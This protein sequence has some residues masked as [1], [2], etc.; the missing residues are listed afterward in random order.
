M[1]KSRGALVAAMALLLVIGGVSVAGALPPTPSSK[2]TPSQGCTC[3]TALLEQW[4]VSMHAQAL[5][6]PL[7]RFKLDQAKK[8]GGEQLG[9][10]CEN[11]HA[12]VAVMSGEI[13]DLSKAT[14]QSLQGVFCDFCHQ[15]T[16]TAGQI[17]NV[18]QT[19]MPD[20]TK[21]AQFDDA[22]SPVHT[23]AYSAFH[24]TAEFCGS[25]HNVDHPSDRTMHLET[26]Y[27][28]W[29]DSPYAADGIVCQDCH[30]TPGPGVTKPNPGTAAGAGPQ[31]DHIYTMT[32]AGGN[33]ALGDAKRAEER[34]KA[35][36]EVTLDAPE[37]VAAGGEAV[38]T[39]T[40]AN[41]G[42]G[43][44]IPTGLTTLREM[45][46][47]LSA[48][49]AAGEAVLVGEHRFGTV[50][51]D[52]KGVAPAEV[53]NAVAVESDDRIR[54]GES[55]T[56]TFTLE[57]PSRATTLTATLYY[58]SCPEAYAKA[59]GVEVPTTTMASAT[60]VVYTSAAERTAAREDP[61]A[62]RNRS[63]AV[64]VAAGGVVLLLA[65]AGLAMRYRRRRRVTSDPPGGFP[66]SG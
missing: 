13:A 6:D 65:V 52:A 56:D 4:S 33:V 51:K 15:V 40:I 50:F 36:A 59:A 49:D 48:I 35:A 29:A 34:L 54:A 5:S 63:V 32:F 62:G 1:R 60:T 24:E 42:A 11:C 44:S 14:P 55:V 26:T 28:E 27:S 20:G 18:S 22:L 19:I 10:F 30:M 41:E 3:H 25:C 43:H 39:V 64:S 23:T 45:W 61:Q 21:R 8:A 7:Y 31:R 58:R 2:F 37:I 38:V 9:R 46:L 16:G 12:P 66:G 17:G 57:M 47:E 53:W